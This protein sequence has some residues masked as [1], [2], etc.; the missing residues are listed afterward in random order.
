VNGA[1]TSTAQPSAI[2]KVI[3]SDYFS[4]VWKV[5][6]AVIVFFVL[7]M[8]AKRIANIASKKFYEHANITEANKQESM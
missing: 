8:L 7:Y 5:G 6:L 2:Q 4:Y 1:N 3:Q